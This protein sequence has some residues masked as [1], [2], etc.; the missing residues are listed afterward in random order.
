MPVKTERRRQRG[1]WNSQMIVFALN[2]L[3][4]FKAHFTQQRKEFLR[5]SQRL[6]ACHC[7]GFASEQNWRKAA[8]QGSQYIVLHKVGLHARKHGEKGSI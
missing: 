7:S 4:S 6:I 3:Y 1:H 8:L 5:I 2:L